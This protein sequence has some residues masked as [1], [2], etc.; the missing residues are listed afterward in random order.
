MTHMTGQFIN[1]SH[2]KCNSLFD[3]RMYSKEN[4]MD[5]HGITVKINIETALF[6]LQ[7]ECEPT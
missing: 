7:V 6:I 4:P 1:K 5:S 2:L 3:K